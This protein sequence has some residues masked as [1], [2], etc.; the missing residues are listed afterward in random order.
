[1]TLMTPAEYAR[2]EEI[3]QILDTAQIDGVAA[4]DAVM[5]DA[6]CEAR[7]ADDLPDP[8]DLEDKAAEYAR[9]TILEAPVPRDLRSMRKEVADEE[10]AIA[11]VEVEERWTEEQEKAD[12]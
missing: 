1:M 5:R 8:V 11:R 4:A 6:I 3:A 2:G 9:E 12:L 7:D 10:A